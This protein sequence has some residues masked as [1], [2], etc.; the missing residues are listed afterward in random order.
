[1]NPTR[2]VHYFERIS[3]AP[4]AISRLRL[5]ILDLA[6]RGKLVEQDC[7]DEP[8]SAESV[9]IRRERRKEIA[10]LYKIPSSWQFRNLRSISDQITDGEHATP[11]RI[12]EQQVPLVTAKNVRDGFMDFRQTDWVS[13]ETATK[14]WKRCRPAVGNILL[15]CVGATTGRLCALRE[16]RDIVLVRSVALIRPSSVANVD[17]LALALRSPMVQSQIWEKV[18]VSAQPCLYINRTNSLL[19][20]VPPLPE[21]RRIVAKV[22]ELMGLC[23]KLEAAQRERESR[24]DGLTASILHHVNNGASTGAF[25]EHAYFYVNHLP[26]LTTSLVHIQQ[27]RQTILNLAVRGRLVAQDPSDIPAS[28]LLREIEADKRRLV[29]PKT[30]MA[31]ED[32]AAISPSEVP[33]QLPLG[34]EWARLGL[35]GD[36]NIGLTY[37]PQDLSDHGVPVLRSNNIRDGKLV[38]SDVVRVDIN[39]KESALVNEGDLL[40]CARNGSR[41]LV[42]KTAIVTGLQERMA[43]GAFMAIFRSR[44]NP[45]IY[46]FICSPLFR[47][48]IDEVNTN[49]INQ[50][51]QA[52]LRS[53][54]VPIPPLAEQRRIVAKVDELMVLCDSL[55]RQ[56]TTA[57]SETSRLLEAVLHQSLVAAC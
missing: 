12:Q 55:E 51:T 50:L 9:C 32:L 4:D 43:F 31:S 53:T 17:Y 44:L 46:D 20:P 13:F 8:V 11:P 36:T 23:D 33:Y 39:V 6:V 22:S 57:R 14:A 15:V 34:W 5:F 10:P 19:I 47:Q 28:E 45:Y 49:T 52:N 38:L 18:K 37:S 25:H 3:D 24:Q 26:R 42:G 48:M 7:K 29:K 2:L 27:L 35:L 41:A 56:V 40:I 30:K 21:Q 54:L 1:M 16:Q